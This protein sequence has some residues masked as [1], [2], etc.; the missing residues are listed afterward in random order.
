MTMLTINLDGVTKP[1]MIR[2]QLGPLRG[3]CPRG[4]MQA[5]P[6]PLPGPSQSV[7]EAMTV[8]STYPRGGHA[9]SSRT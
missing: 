3:S 7:H 5:I 2:A 4:H 9:Q 1:M 8:K 6:D